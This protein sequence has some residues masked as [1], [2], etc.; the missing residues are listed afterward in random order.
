[1]ASRTSLVIPNGV[2]RCKE[3]KRQRICVV[4]FFLMPVKGYLSYASLYLVRVHEKYV[5][6]DIR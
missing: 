5:N 3:Q 6:F 1:M 2:H 4:Q